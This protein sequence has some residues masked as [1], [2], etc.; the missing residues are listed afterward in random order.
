MM[1]QSEIQIKDAGA[2][3]SDTRSSSGAGTLGG[4]KGMKPSTLFTIAA[5]EARPSVHLQVHS[6]YFQSSES[7]V[8][9]ELT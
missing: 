7:Q 6:V 2:S 1:G 9:L 5:Q 4:L 8:A 3:R